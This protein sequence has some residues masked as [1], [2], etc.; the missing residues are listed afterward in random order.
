M[1]TFSVAEQV[2]TIHDPEGKSTGAS[3]RLESNPDD[4]SIV[5]MYLNDDK[6]NA[7]R[8]DFNKQGLYIGET[9]LSIDDENEL[10]EERLEAVE[11]ADDRPKDSKGNFIPLTDAQKFQIEAKARLDYKN[12]IRSQATAE[13]KAKFV[14]AEK[15]RAAAAKKAA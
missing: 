12:G 9:Y 2:V 7:H 1:K 14:E 8:F 10:V 6:G 15:A 3:I 13:R 4:A 11:A 5:H